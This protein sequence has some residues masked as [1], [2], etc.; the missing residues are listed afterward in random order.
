MYFARH[1]FLL[2]TL[3]LFYETVARAQ[4]LDYPSKQNNKLEGL[5]QQS[6]QLQ[7]EMLF[8][9][10][11]VLFKEAHL[12]SKVNDDPVSGV[13]CLNEISKCYRRLHNLQQAKAYADSAIAEGKQVLGSN[14][15]LLAECYDNIG[16]IGIIDKSSPMTLEYLKRSLNIKLQNNQQECET[17]G[18]SYRYI[19]VY[20]EGQ[21]DTIES[22]KYLNRANEIYQKALPPN[23]QKIASINNN[24]G[25]YYK[26]I[27]GH[28]EKA[29][30]HYLKALEIYKANFGE[31]DFRVAGISNN[32]ALAYQII[33]QPEQEERYLLYALGIQ[34][35]LL[36]PHDPDLGMTYFNLASFYMDAGKFEQALQYLQMSIMVY[37]PGFENPDPKV[38]P[39]AFETDF[40]K[41]L[42]NPLKSKPEAFL[43]IYRQSGDTNAL[44]MAVDTWLL[45]S[46]LVDEFFKVEYTESG[47]L[48][49]SETMTHVY[50]SGA[51]YA[52]LLYELTG[53]PKDLEVAFSF[54]E[55]HKARLLVDVLSELL[56]ADTEKKIPDSL[57]QLEGK[58]N[59][60]IACLENQIGLLKTDKK[61]IEPGKMLQLLED[62]L[63]RLKSRYFQL[64][65]IITTK[66]PFC[67]DLKTRAKS[68]SIEQLQAI[69]DSNESIL[70]YMP[71]DLGQ[72]VR[73]SECSVIAIFL[74]QRNKADL[75]FIEID[76]GFYAN[77]KKFRGNILNKRFGP[78]AVTD[79]SHLAYGI[80]EKTIGPFANDIKNDNLIIVPDGIL[81]IVPFEILISDALVAVNNFKDLP[82]LIKNHIV[83]YNYSSSFYYYSLKKSPNNDLKNFLALA[84]AFEKQDPSIESL[85]A[86]RG[87]VY[88]GL[89]GAKREVVKI[90]EML[91]GRAIVGNAATK[92]CF[93]ENAGNYNILHL[94]THSFVDEDKPMNSRILFSDGQRL[95]GYEEMFA[96]ELFNTRLHAEMAVLSTC[97]SGCGKIHN[98]EGVLS[99]ARNFIYAGVPNVVMSLWNISDNTSATIMQ[100]FYKNLKKNMPKDEALRNAKLDFVGHADNIMAHPYYWGGM[101]LVGNQNSI[102]V[103]TGQNLDRIVFI[104]LG[105]FVILALFWLMRKKLSS[106]K[107]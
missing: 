29:L 107:V 101:V 64:E 59:S 32:I 21:N 17:V 3:F 27:F 68:V 50:H 52:G 46:C 11:I 39:V 1:F 25:L 24:I 87:D 86:Q 94:A 102:D 78:N 8:D 23:H 53:N 71:L 15:P 92:K 44:R 93:L 14:H 81:G 5:L 79:F 76:Q 28:N 31:V 54:A 62:S 56:V 45:T 26:R 49:L 99:L 40:K 35:Q 90:N 60:E 70:Q 20:L 82:Y 33:N 66:Y 97:S 30:K 77:I 95:G 75:K 41:E 69:L 80:Y 67:S 88:V 6:Y 47:K 18:D 13:K 100:A 63:F 48:S 91:N 51:Y 65:K 83:L 61:N 9:T 38:N 74:I 104:V 37:L 22:I 43:G 19:G 73:P 72:P 4:G 34:E 85:Y 42:F 36:G 89:S 58:Y 96:F 12:L 105:V 10:A 98:S 16:I 103:A 55:K 7:K 2:I 57:L 106:P 84:P